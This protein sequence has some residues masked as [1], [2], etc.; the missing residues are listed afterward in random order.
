MIAC[1]I[2]QLLVR[3]GAGVNV[4][5][6]SDANA[7]ANPL[8]KFTP[9]EAAAYCGKMEIL[10]ELLA[11]GG[12][13]REANQALL[14]HGI[15]CDEVLR[16]VNPTGASESLVEDMHR[17]FSEELGHLPERVTRRKFLSWIQSARSAA[18]THMFGS[19]MLKTFVDMELLGL[20]PTKVGTVSVANVE[21]QCARYS[22]MAESYLERTRVRDH[23][24]M[25]YAA[26]KDDAHALGF[27]SCSKIAHPKS[28]TT[29][30][31][32]H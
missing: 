15:T 31:S 16:S 26:A 22:F 28:S 21:Q 14:P 4:R 20:D 9:V 2:V 18:L 7:T 27:F 17:A 23:K 19:K 5:V 11:F 29:P 24:L 10:T 8:A 1:G 30:V 3:Q 12:D 13:K 6:N 32:P 25:F